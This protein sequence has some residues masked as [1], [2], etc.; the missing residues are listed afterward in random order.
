MI[1]GRRT[2]GR[3]HR[4]WETAG[5]L[6]RGLL[7]GALVVGLGGYAYRVGE[8][9]SHARVGKLENDLERFQRD[10][11]A[12]RDRLT[13]AVAR[14]DQASGA[15][16]RLRRRYAKDVPDGRLAALVDRLEAQLAAGVDAERLTFLIEAAGQEVACATDPETKRFAPRTPITEGPISFV[17]IAERV[18]ITGRGES[19]RTEDGLTEAW[20]DPGRPI[21]LDFQTLDGAVTT[22]EGIV[23]IQHRM[24]V[25]GAEYRFSVVNGERSFVEVT[26]Q[27]C[28]LPG[29]PVDQP[30]EA[31]EGPAEAIERSADAAEPPADALDAAAAPDPPA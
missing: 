1:G 27:I 16:D 10:N 8:S 31:V 18:T 13:G 14:A 23:P 17:R 24:I 7:L 12:L 26:A 11:L 30:A 6:L 19:A 28:E 4:G 5:R 3:R 9:A 29:A 22:I 15:L 2:F 20:F 25:D 21:R